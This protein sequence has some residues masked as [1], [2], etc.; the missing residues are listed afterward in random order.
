IDNPPSWLPSDDITLL[1]LGYSETLDQTKWTIALNCV[2][3]SPYHVPAWATSSTVG[4]AHWDAESSTLNSGCTTTATSLSVAFTSGTTR[5]TTDSD[6]FSFDIQ[7]GGERIT[8]TAI[9]S[10]T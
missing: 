1:A 8:V 10:T 3:E 5:W 9:S 4:S 7:I 2:P 6:A